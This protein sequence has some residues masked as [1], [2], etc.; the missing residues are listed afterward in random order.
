ML[1]LISKTARNHP[2]QDQKQNKDKNKAELIAFLWQ[3]I[4]LTPLSQQVLNERVLRFLKLSKYNRSAAL[5]YMN[6]QYVAWTSGAI[7][8]ILK[9]MT[10]KLAPFVQWTCPVKTTDHSENLVMTSERQDRLQ[11]PTYNKH[12]CI[13]K[14]KQGNMGQKRSTSRN[15]ACSA[16]HRI[17]DSA[18]NFAWTSLLPC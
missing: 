17:N 5:T 8:L 18:V 7:D 15:N 6:Q 13:N 9:A 10:R 12:T 16:K 1:P 2:E 3:F 4:I 14:W 11:E